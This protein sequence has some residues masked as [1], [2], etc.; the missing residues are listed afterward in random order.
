MCQCEPDAQLWGREQGLW[1]LQSQHRAATAQ[2]TQALHTWGSW[3]RSGGACDSAFPANS[4]VR[5]TPTATSG[6]AAADEEPG[7][8]PTRVS[9]VAATDVPLTL[10]VALFGGRGGEHRSEPPL[11]WFLGLHLTAIHFCSELKGISFFLTYESL[12]S[13][14]FI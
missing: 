14:K 7:G 2:G 11:T 8:G 4:Q 6:T 12:M 10:H 5:L 13:L 1:P 3:G 9:A